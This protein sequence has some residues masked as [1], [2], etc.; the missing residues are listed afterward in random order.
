MSGCLGGE[1]GVFDHAGQVKDTRQLRLRRR[2]LRDEGARRGGIG[3]VH[4][5]QRDRHSSLRPLIQRGGRCGGGRCA[6][7]QYQMA[8]AATDQ[9]LGG[10]QSQGST[11]PGDEV[12]VIC[13]DHQPWMIAL[14]QRLQSQHV[15]IRPL[16]NNLILAGGL[17]QFG[18]DA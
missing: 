15:P 4:R 2:E 6:P 18:D 1:G 9:P 12:G 3:E 17:R 11:S 14:G 5:R 10:E 16:T 7:H 8:G 13:F